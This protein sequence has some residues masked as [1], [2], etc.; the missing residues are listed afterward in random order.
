[1]AEFVCKNPGRSG[2]G[3]DNPCRIVLKGEAQYLD[4]PDCC[5][6]GFG[7]YQQCEFEVVKDGD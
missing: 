1:M 4:K 6:Y 2:C 7:K 3:E 5:P